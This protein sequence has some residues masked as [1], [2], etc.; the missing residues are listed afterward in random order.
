MID[1]GLQGNYCL[2]LIDHV[3]LLAFA[4]NLLKTMS[5]KG[6]IFSLKFTKNR[7]S[8]GLRSYPLEQLQRSSDP[9][10][11]IGGPILL[12]GGQGRIGG[13]GKGE[14]RQGEGEE[15]GEERRGREG[16]VPHL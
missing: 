10:S 12:T 11:A 15:R 7:L 14:E 9:L 4:E 13:G 6:A 3:E 16:C 8:A 2:F 5:A 1:V